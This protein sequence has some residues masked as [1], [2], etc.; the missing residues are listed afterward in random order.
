VGARELLADLLDR[1][2]DFLQVVGL[3]EDGILRLEFEFA[4]NVADALLQRQVGVGHLLFV[5]LLL[6]AQ[7]IE[8]EKVAQNSNMIKL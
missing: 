8:F 3:A 4:G 7:S 1:L 6:I 2:A 5:Y